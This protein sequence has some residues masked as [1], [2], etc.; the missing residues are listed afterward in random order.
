[1]GS[2]NR[3]RTSPQPLPRR[4]IGVMVKYRGGA[5]GWWELSYAGRTVR[6]EGF[7]ALHDAMTH[8]LGISGCEGCFSVEDVT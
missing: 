1:M 2:N 7:L 4:T 6:V 5:Q 8:L 3:R